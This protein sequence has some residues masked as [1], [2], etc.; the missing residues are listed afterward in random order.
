MSIKQSR[1]GV[2]STG[3]NIDRFVMEN[4]GIRCAVL[5]YG[6]ILQCLEVPDRNGDMADVTLGF[7][8]LESYEKRNDPYLGALIGRCGN[9]LALG[10]FTLDGKSYQLVQNNAQNHLHGGTKGFDKKAWTAEIVGDQ[11]LRLSLVSPDGEENYPGTL[12]CSVT[13][14]VDADA[15]TLDY[16]AETDAPTILNLT[17]HAY[18]NLGGHGAGPIDPHRVQIH[19]DRYTPVDE[20]LIPT[21]ELEDVK[22]TPMDLRQPT[23]LAEG[24]RALDGYDHNF[25]LNKRSANDPSVTVAHPGSGRIMD[26]FTTEPGVQFYTGNFLDDIR[27]K[28]GAI[29]ERHG[30]FCLEAQHFPDSIH[31]AEF[32]TV[33]LRPGETYRQTTRYCFRTGDM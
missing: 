5:N 27:G 14:R 1:F 32:P 23:S 18:Y 31:Q 10:Q 13:V 19:A 9:R 20:T 17:Q 6:G 28:G 25:V 22:G 26:M 12:S 33:V 11:S 21:G 24:M 3:E 16:T 30:G 7:D 29:Y 15:F 8:D 4:G 2:L